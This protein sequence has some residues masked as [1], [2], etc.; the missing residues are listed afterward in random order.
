MDENIKMNKEILKKE[1]NEGV[2]A[3]DNNKLDIALKKFEFVFK[4]KQ[5]EQPQQLNQS[6]TPVSA[7]SHIIPILNLTPYFAPPTSVM[8]NENYL[9]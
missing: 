9:T 6:R 8:S 5:K 3:L 7:S 4:H 1:F 2:I